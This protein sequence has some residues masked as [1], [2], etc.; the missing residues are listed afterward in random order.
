[1]VSKKRWIG[2]IVVILMLSLFLMNG[3]GEKG[4]EEKNAEGI[5]K[6]VSK[7]ATAPGN[8]DIGL[9]MYPGA[10]VN[11]AYPPISAPHLKNIHILTGDPLE[12]VVEWYSQKLGKFDV[13]SQKNGT[14]ALWH[15]EASD[16]FFMTVTISTMTAP[17]GQVE[18]TMNKMKT[19]K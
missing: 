17:A 15:K 4:S 7:E 3:C 6:Q 1:M 12:K 10:K 11:P 5:T 2:S 16:G 18:I 14:Q 8:M 19:E 9:P 13:D